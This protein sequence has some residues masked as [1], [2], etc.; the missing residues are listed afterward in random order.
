MCYMITAKH[1][2][3]IPELKKI[4]VK[5]YSMRKLCKTV[6]WTQFII[7][8]VKF[9]YIMCRSTKIVSNQ[10]SSTNGGNAA[11]DRI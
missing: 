7:S 3:F 11:L 1:I 6:C 9:S 5:Y 2:F 8:E 10:K 4:T